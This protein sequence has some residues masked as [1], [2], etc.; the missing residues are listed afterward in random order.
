MQILFYK[1]TSKLV[2]LNKYAPAVLRKPGAFMIIAFRK[3]R[4]SQP[5]KTGYSGSEKAALCLYFLRE[6]LSGTLF[7]PAIL[8]PQNETIDL[9][10]CEPIK[11]ILLLKTSCK[12][13]RSIRPNGFKAFRYSC[14]RGPVKAASSGF[15]R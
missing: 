11:R 10:R 2:L 13:Y 15:Y 7:V 8:S 1:S 6:A 9:L 14:L 3:S 5:W 12:P 4:I